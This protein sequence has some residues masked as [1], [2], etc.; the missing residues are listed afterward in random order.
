MRPFLITLPVLVALL[1]LGI[2]WLLLKLRALNSERQQDWMKA[3]AVV[4]EAS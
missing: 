3:A 1:G 2:A 4:G